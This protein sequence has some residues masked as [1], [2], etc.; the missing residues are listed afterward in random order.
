MS[1]APRLRGPV[2][3][4]DG[5]TTER[6]GI[7]VLYDCSINNKPPSKSSHIAGTL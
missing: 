5:S 1:R 4:I 3:W 2:D 7:H 6:E